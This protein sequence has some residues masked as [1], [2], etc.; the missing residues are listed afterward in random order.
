MSKKPSN[1]HVVPTANGKWTV[2]KSGAERASK[3]FDKQ[4][5][6][7]EWARIKSKTERS[8]LVIH[9]RDGTIREKD[10]YGRDPSPPRDKKR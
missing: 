3:R 4:S 1:V 6:A 8:E 7:V 5:D 9:K 10:S 2:K